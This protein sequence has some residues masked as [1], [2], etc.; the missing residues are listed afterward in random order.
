[1]AVQELAQ[2]LFEAY[3]GE[4]LVR[5]DFAAHTSIGG[6]VRHGRPRRWTELPIA[7]QDCWIA[8]ARVAS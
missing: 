2:R 5:G 1:V 4:R 7:E 6:I 8:A 3:E